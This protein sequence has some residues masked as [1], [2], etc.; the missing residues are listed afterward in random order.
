VAGF[1]SG[2]LNVEFID[3]IHTMKV[4]ATRKTP[5]ARHLKEALEYL[6][7]ERPA[8]SREWALMTGVSFWEEDHLYG[9]LQD[10]YDYFYGDRKEPPVARIRRRRRPGSTGREGGRPGP[11]SVRRHLASELLQPVRRLP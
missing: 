1:F 11:E 3:E 2:A 9:Y 8:G 4:G 7:R 6:L 5:Y 10:L